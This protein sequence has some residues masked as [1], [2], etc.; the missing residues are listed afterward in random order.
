MWFI[1]FFWAFLG[2]QLWHSAIRCPFYFCFC[3]FTQFF[4]S[5]VFFIY[6]IFRQLHHQR[7][8]CFSFFIAFHLQFLCRHC[9]SESSSVPQWTSSSLSLSSHSSFTQISTQQ[10]SL[11]LSFTYS[12][13]LA[14]LP[15]CSPWRSHLL[16]SLQFKFPPFAANENKTRHRRSFALPLS[17]F[18][19]QVYAWLRHF[20]SQYDS[21]LHSERFDFRFVFSYL[22]FF[23][24]VFLLLLCIF[25]AGIHWH[26]IW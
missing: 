8:L 22:H 9:A 24:L 26:S 19:S 25:A 16:R 18:H 21:R 5:L 12:L 13:A 15:V 4:A 3:F 11:S 7:C 23:H 20:M 6:W 10:P 2:C 1:I 17:P 14:L